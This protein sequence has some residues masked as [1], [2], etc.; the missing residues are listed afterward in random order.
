MKRLLLPA[1]VL[2]LASCDRTPRTVVIDDNPKYCWECTHRIT[3]TAND[4]SYETMVE[5]DT[6]I[7]D[8]TGIEIAAVMDQRDTG[9]ITVG[10][11]VLSNVRE[12]R[13]CRRQ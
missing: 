9:Y 1:T 12:V 5:R 7:C 2:L 11:F 6:V 13:D 8:K 4:G 10:A 3:S